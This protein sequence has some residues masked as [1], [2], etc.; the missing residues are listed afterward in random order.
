MWVEIAPNSFRIKQ[1]LRPFGIAIESP[2]DVAITEGLHKLFTNAQDFALRGLGIRLKQRREVGWNFNR[3]F[4]CARIVLDPLGKRFN[5]RRAQ[6]PARKQ[7]I[8]V[9]PA[10]ATSLLCGIQGIVS[11][12]KVS[13]VLS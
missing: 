6:L 11:A 12:V 3:A 10:H 2:A 1:I 4:G 5:S 7:T 8:A 13:R 9:H